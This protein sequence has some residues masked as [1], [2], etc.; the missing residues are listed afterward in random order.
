MQRHMNRYKILLVEDEELIR[1]L[2]SEAIEDEGFEVV[3]ACDGDEAMLCLND[4]GCFDLL[5]TDI[6]MP[7]ILD[8]LDIARAARARTPGL[9][10]IFTTGQPD[11]MSRW[12]TGSAEAFFP[13]PYRP[14]EIFE[15]IRHL[16]FEQAPASE[17]NFTN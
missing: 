15:A 1:K 16:I 5:L 14:S 13:K 17:Q 3:S 2:L 9:P 11:R 10:I 12:H 7:G 8:G 4:G 6:Q